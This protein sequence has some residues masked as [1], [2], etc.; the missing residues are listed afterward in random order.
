M[1][2]QYSEIHEDESELVEEEEKTPFVPMFKVGVL[3]VLL[4][5]C[6][7]MIAGGAITFTRS[8]KVLRYKE[9]NAVIGDGYFIEKN[10]Y[11]VDYVVDD[12]DYRNDFIIKKE[13][14]EGDKIKAYYDPKKPENCVLKKMVNVV[15]LL[16]AIAGFFIAKF[17][18]PRLKKNASEAKA[19]YKELEI[20]E[21]EA[22][23]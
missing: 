6:L 16:I 1:I 13:Y 3:I 2:N 9:V 18:I 19:F 14:K 23:E 12:K 20:E 15:A 17:L 7:G 11:N 4:I 5:V 8:L 10:R 21:K 22:E